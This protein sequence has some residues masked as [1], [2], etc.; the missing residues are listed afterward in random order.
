MARHRATGVSWG[1]GRSGL[2]ETR[3]CIKLL[4]ASFSD[5]AATHSMRLIIDQSPIPYYQWDLITHVVSVFIHMFHSEN[6][7]ICGPA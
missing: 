5:P 6:D 4:L 7:L 2:A 1:A 3:G